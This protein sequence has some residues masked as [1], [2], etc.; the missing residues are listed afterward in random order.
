M[1]DLQRGMLV[2]MLNAT[3]EDFN[4]AIG[5]LEN[6]L[7]DIELFVRNSLDDRYRLVIIDDNYFREVRGLYEQLRSGNKVSY[8][9][10]AFSLELLR[11]CMSKYL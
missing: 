1:D 6:L 11:E 4:L 9:K 10:T 8:S 2:K 7:I 5:I 3:D